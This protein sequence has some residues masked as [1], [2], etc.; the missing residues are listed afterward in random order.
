MNTTRVGRIVKQY[1]RYYANKEK[2]TERID[3]IRIH[4]RSITFNRQ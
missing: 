1:T 3:F 2:N 4:G